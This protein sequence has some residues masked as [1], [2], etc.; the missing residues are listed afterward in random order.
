MYVLLKTDEVHALFISGLLVLVKKNYCITIHTQWAKYGKN[1]TIQKRVYCK[2]NN[3]LYKWAL[4]GGRQI[5]HKMID[6]VINWNSVD[7][8]SIR[9]ICTIHCKNSFGI[10]S[11]Y[12]S[13][14]RSHYTVRN[15]GELDRYIKLR[16]RV[17]SL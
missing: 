14:L 1:Y 15:K 13:L 8:R 17:W 3:I 6:W 7:C 10:N 5:Q 11:N 9:V 4:I 2:E 16:L 12:L